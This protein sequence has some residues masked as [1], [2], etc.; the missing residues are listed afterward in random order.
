MRTYNRDLKRARRWLAAGRGTK[1][2]H[3]LEPKVPL[4]LEDPHYYTILGRACLESGLLKDADTYL[5][6]GLQSDPTNVEVRLTLAVN[7][8]KR[9]DPAAAVRT[10][11]EVLED[12][13]DDKYASRGLKTLKGITSQEAQDKF[14]T[15]FQ[16]RRLL[17]DIRSRWPSRILISLLVLLFLL[18][19]LYFAEEIGSVVSSILGGHRRLGYERFLVQEDGSL[20]IDSDDIALSLNDAEVTRTMKK[21]MRHFQA[22]EDNKA[23]YELNKILNSNASAEIRDQAEGLIKSLKEPEI[24]GFDNFFNYADVKASPWLFNGCWVLWKG[25]TA[26]VVYDDDAIRF[27][28]LVGFEEGQVLEGRVPVEIPFLTVMEPLP[29]E[30]LAKVEIQDEGFHLVGKTLHF[31]R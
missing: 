7:H 21:A 12:H 17:P 29:L 2:I 8:L 3:Y 10:W 4:F 16:P 13:H 28:F 5:N 20:T 23:R 22:Y 1:V 30:L 31:L 25:M 9:K 27:D 19:G 24:E 26:N 11:L 18:M 15:S 14:L 6:R